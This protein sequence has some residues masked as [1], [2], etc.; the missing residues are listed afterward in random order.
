[1]SISAHTYS[2]LGNNWILGNCP[3]C[4]LAILP[5]SFSRWTGDLTFGT[6]PYPADVGSRTAPDRHASPCMTCSARHSNL[7]G[8]LME[9]RHDADWGGVRLTYGSSRARHNIYRR[10]ESSEDA[11]VICE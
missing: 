10:G 2:R 1:M 3:A 4:I 5:S 11:I 6:E 8:S 9:H 7:C